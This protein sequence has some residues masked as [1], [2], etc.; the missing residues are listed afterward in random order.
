[1]A[2]DDVQGDGEQSRAEASGPPKANAYQNNPSRA[3]ATVGIAVVTARDSK[4]TKVISATIPT[5][6][7]RYG[8]DSTPGRVV[9]S[10]SAVVMPRTLGHQAHLK[11]TQRASGQRTAASSSARIGGT[12]CSAA[13]RA[14]RRSEA[15]ST[16]PAPAMQAQANSEI[17]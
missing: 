16:T 12:A 4:A 7:A 15:T 11:S 10:D 9:W 14:I 1:M 17:A 3:C 5:V 6:N 13:A 8:G 2:D